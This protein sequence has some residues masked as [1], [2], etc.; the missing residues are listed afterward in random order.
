MKDFGKKL[1]RVTF[2]IAL[3]GFGVKALIHFMGKMECCEGED[4]HREPYQ[5]EE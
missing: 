3:L 5:P 2:A 4:E 1:L